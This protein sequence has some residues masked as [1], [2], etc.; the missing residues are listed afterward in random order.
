M[1][2]LW[3]LKIIYLDYVMGIIVAFWFKVVSIPATKL[4]VK[5]MF[6]LFMYVSKIKIKTSV[7]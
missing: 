5:N 7:L 3:L 1:T 2:V 6:I 4:S